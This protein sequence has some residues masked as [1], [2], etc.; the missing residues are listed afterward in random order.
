M[1]L[2][3][4]GMAGSEIPKKRGFLALD[5]PGV[6]GAA[7]L[8][9]NYTIEEVALSFIKKISLLPRDRSREFSVV[10]MSYGGMVTSLLG[11]LFRSKLPA[12]TTF[13]YLVTSPNLPENKA[14]KDPLLHSWMS[15][16]K[17]R[18]AYFERVLTPFFSPGFLREKRDEFERYKDYRMKGGN[19]QSPLEFFRQLGAIEKYDGFRAFKSVDPTESHFVGGSCD[20]IFG[21][22]HSQNLKDLCP[23]GSHVEVLGLGHMINIEAPELFP[24]G[25]S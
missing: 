20:R 7:P 1:V 9:G 15:P 21:P 3:G 25:A 13:H 16:E 5:H 4:V 10:G 22:S 6:A 23:E 17:D 12:K 19:L 14:I 11:G 18:D 8:S 2:A 24:R